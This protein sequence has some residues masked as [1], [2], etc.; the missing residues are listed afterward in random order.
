MSRGKYFSRS[1]FVC[2]AFSLSVLFF[3]SLSLFLFLSVNFSQCACRCLSL[4]PFKSVCFLSLLSAPVS[5]CSVPLA[6]F[7]SGCVLLSCLNETEANT[8]P[9]C[10]C[11][12]NFEYFMVFVHR[13]IIAL[14][15]LLTCYCECVYD[16]RMLSTPCLIAC[17]C[18]FYVIRGN[19]DKLID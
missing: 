19:N 5:V 7:L 15:T 18:V 10:D 17:A 13:I 16:P 14:Y 2:L 1:L 8:I 12:F 6:L 3:F 9:G 11:A 4:P